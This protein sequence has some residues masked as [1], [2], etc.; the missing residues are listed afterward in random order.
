MVCEQILLRFRE[1]QQASR[2]RSGR[3]WQIC[4]LSPNHIDSCGFVSSKHSSPHPS[5]HRYYYPLVIGDSSLQGSEASGHDS[6]LEYSAQLE[7]QLRC[8][9][10]TIR[11]RAVQR[12]PDRALGVRRPHC[13]IRT[14]I[15]AE[16]PGRGV[17][18][19]TYVCCRL[20]VERPRPA[21]SAWVAEAR[22]A[23][24]S[25]ALRCPVLD[26]AARLDWPARAS[27]GKLR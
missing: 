7:L 19:S 11:S 21:P 18:G 14:A 17:R 1:N 10:R 4:L 15:C 26:A 3:C 6:E 5:I 13:G 27:A 16:G 20:G 8:P 23:A 25:A 12:G 9:A 22:W 2:C 24:G